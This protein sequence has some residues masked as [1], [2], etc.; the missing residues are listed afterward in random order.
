M[1]MFLKVQRLIHQLERKDQ[2]TSLF[3]VGYFLRTEF[4][5]CP[6][7]VT[8]PVVAGINSS[9]DFI[10]VDFPAPFGPIIPVIFV[11]LSSS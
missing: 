2:F 11:D 3:H 6:E 8:L 1:D 4:T 7:K 10:N 9:K 5:G